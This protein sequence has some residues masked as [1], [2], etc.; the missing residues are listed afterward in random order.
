V[1]NLSGGASAALSRA[2]RP[3]RRLRLDVLKKR[4]SNNSYQ[5]REPGSGVGGRRPANSGIAAAG[6]PGDGLNP[7]K[8][9]LVMA[10]VFPAGLLLKVRGQMAGPAGRGELSPQQAATVSPFCRL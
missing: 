9:I 2:Q 7:E 10:P 5:I 8:K 4:R 1:F 3:A 6:L